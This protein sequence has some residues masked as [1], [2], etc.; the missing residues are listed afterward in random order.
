MFRIFLVSWALLEGNQRK[1]LGFVA[2]ARLFLNLADIFGILLVVQ[3]TQGL[4]QGDDSEGTT[5]LGL[6]GANFGPDVLLVLAGATFVAKGAL[7]VGLAKSTHN[8]L[9]E[10]ENQQSRKVAQHVFGRGLDF[11]DR[12]RPSEIEWAILRS[13][14]FAFVRILGQGIQFCVEAFMIFLI[15]ALFIWTDWQIAISALIYFAIVVVIFQRITY[16]IQGRSGAEFRDASS[17]VTETISQVIRSFRELYVAGRV[18][19]FLDYLS[20]YRRTVARTTAVD[21]YLQSIPRLFIETALLIGAL[22]YALFFALGDPSNGGWSDVPV[23]LVGSLRMM[24]SVLPLQ[25]ALVAIRFWAP[26]AEGAQRILSDA[27]AANEV[28]TKNANIESDRFEESVTIEFSNVVFGY[29]E[30]GAENVRPV[31]DDVSFSIYQGERIAVVGDSGS[32]K[33]TLV[34]LLL[35]LK[36]PNEGLILINGEP[37]ERFV[38]RH[39]GVFGFVPQEIGMI[40]GS[41]AENV[42][43][44]YDIDE[45]QRELIA[46]CLEVAQLTPIIAALPEGIDTDIGKHLDA[47]SGGQLQRISIARALFNRP[48]VLI[49]DEATSALDTRTESSLLKH[50]MAHQEGVT[51]L[52]ITHRVTSLDRSWDIRRL[53][54]GQLTRDSVG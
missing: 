18:Q 39:P 14:E 53:K 31:L 41:I 54:N 23:F 5:F 20:G 19:G 13:T 44:S 4:S 9:A 22:L 27:S 3:A 12:Y 48:R 49:L 47:L 15:A 2:F 37:A 11:T 40:R 34:D 25:R 21:L 6:A 46:G 28:F 30:P 38:R 51:V 43:L 33:S 24:S 7:G 52:M 29:S 10:V 50:L 45:H 32:G 26:Q 35:G 17:R 42:A 8:L 16:A 1:R 36:S